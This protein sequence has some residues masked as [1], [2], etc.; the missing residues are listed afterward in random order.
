MGI[1]YQTIIDQLGD[2]IEIVTPLAL[3]L[4]LCQWVVRFIL[5]AFLG[6]YKGDLK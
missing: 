3:T 4:G 1:D 6:G 5:N 2:I